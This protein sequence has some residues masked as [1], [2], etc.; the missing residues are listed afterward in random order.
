MLPGRPWSDAEADAWDLFDELVASTGK[1]A[2]LSNRNPAGGTLLINSMLMYL[3]SVC[4][5]GVLGVDPRQGHP[6]SVVAH[7]DRYC[8][9][10]DRRRR[11]RCLRFLELAFFASDLFTQPSHDLLDGAKKALFFGLVAR[12]GVGFNECNF[13]ASFLI[14]LVR[15][16]C[17]FARLAQRHFVKLA[18]HSC[19]VPL[20]VLLHDSLVSVAS[21]LSYAREDSS[22]LWMLEL[23]Q[24]FGNALKAGPPSPEQVLQLLRDVNFV[25]CCR[26]LDSLGRGPRGR[27]LLFHWIRA[28]PIFRRYLF[29][30]PAPSAG[31]QDKFPSQN[32]NDPCA[33]LKELVRRRERTALELLHNLEPELFTQHAPQMLTY[34]R[35]MKQGK[36]ERIEELLV[37]AAAQPKNTHDS[38]QL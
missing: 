3:S 24:V 6:Y 32:V 29:L 8:S 33:L 22:E 15:P 12:G 2:W 38:T 13:L 16:S 10:S 20:P 30:G 17:R 28:H 26:L 7:I 4:R 37:Q 27:A 18:A 35:N 36:T 21:A 14:R 5:P 25:T 31:I 19:C 34:L 9:E 1:M 23:L 11:F